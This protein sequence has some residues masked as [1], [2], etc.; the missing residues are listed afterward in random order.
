MTDAP[1]PLSP[2]DCATME[3]L[4][5]GIDAL[6]EQIVDLLVA[7]AA[8][9]DRAAQI[10]AQAGLPA[11]IPVR[12]EQVVANVRASATRAGL[13]PDL[14]EGLWRRMIAWSIAREE[15]TLGPGPRPEKDMP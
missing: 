3:D 12:V 10:K 1:P 9:I 2:E 8:Y 14:V 5:A 4:R 13:D 15:E 7:R 11:T 6:D